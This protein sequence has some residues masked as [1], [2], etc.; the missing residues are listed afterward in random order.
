MDEQ[1]GID[2]DG[3]DSRREDLFVEM[4]IEKPVDP[5]REF[6][7][8]GPRG[9]T[10]TRSDYSISTSPDAPLSP[11]VSLRRRLSSIHGDVVPSTAATAQ[12]RDTTSWERGTVAE[13][14][15]ED[16]ELRRQYRMGV[17]SSF[18]EC[19]TS[20]LDVVSGVSWGWGCQ[21]SWRQEHEVELAADMKEER[22]KVGT[23]QQETVDSLQQTEEGVIEETVQTSS[24]SCLSRGAHRCAH[25]YLTEIICGL[26]VGFAQV[27]ESVAFAFMANVYPS[28][29]L[30]AA[31]IV[32]LCA[33]ALG[34]R[35]GMINGAT[36][37]FAAVISGFVTRT[38]DGHVYKYDGIETLFVSVIFSSVLMYA[39]AFF[40]LSSLVQ[41]IPT[42]VQI[43][44]CNG[45]AVVIFKS[46]FHVFKDGTTHTWYTGCVAAEM[47][48]ICI[49]AVL[50]M[51]FWP[52]VPKVG[53]L[54]PSTLLAMVAAIL[55]EFGLFRPLV[56]TPT[57]VIKDVAQFTTADATPTLFFLDSRYNMSNIEWGWPLVLQSIILFLVGCMESTMTVEVVNDLHGNRGHSDQQVFAMAVG[58][59][60]A[61][62]FGGMG[63]NSMIGLSVLN[64]RSG[65]RGKE[66]G[67][68]AALCV[69]IMLVGGYRALNYFPVA[70]LAGVMFVVCFHTFKW[71]SVGMVLSCFLPYK[72]R[73]LSAFLH[74]KIQRWDAV[75]IVLVTVITAIGN[76]A[77]AV[78][79]GVFISASVFAWNCM[80]QFTVETSYNYK[81]D[82]KYYE[83]DGPL[84]FA[85]KMKFEHLFRPTTDPST[86][87]VIVRGGRGLL[88][89]Y[90]A[91]EA[92]N[93]VKRLYH[94][95]NKQLIL[96]GLSVN[97]VKM[98]AKANRI[99]RYVDAD[100]EQM[101]IPA[102]PRLYERS[103]EC[104]QEKLTDEGS[105]SGGMCQQRGSGLR[106]C[107]WKWKRRCCSASAPRRSSF[108][109]NS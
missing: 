96:Q 6:I 80:T 34:G 10:L 3:D 31:W 94:Q 59:T 66:T 42:S 70:A 35:P 52:Y 40:R 64:Y 11:S 92:I 44:F 98:C 76:L 97:C 87:V 27:P 99:L 61:G 41:L 30:H 20:C 72:I 103:L 100:M 19:W 53:K 26:I 18:N 38:Y 39:F 62:M 13:K 28:V 43:G 47:A 102:V 95:E 77:L 63:G 49:V 9:I 109:P 108:E 65:G 85:S 106:G 37:T 68:V 7:L 24:T 74:M 32:G 79:V 89:D 60:V 86:V 107:N 93:S 51:F 36:G 57:P 55:I 88:M 5:T 84:F 69:L 33:T 46:Q 83:V 101:E 4:S 23:L 75:V 12:Q 67:V 8:A 25:F 29:G 71:F 73:K 78:A 48:V 104:V 1:D 16:E 15:E 50:V 81:T 90:S 58:N 54:I 56:H 14:A 105:L 45:L 82:T 21:R 17:C 91:M 22:R 2:Q